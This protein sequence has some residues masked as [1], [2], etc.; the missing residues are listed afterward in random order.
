MVVV[1]VSVF[2]VAMVV[3]Q[4]EPAAPQEEEREYDAQRDTPVD[5]ELERLP[6]YCSIHPS[7]D[8][9]GQYASN[10]AG[11]PER[12]RW[13]EY[14]GDSFQ[15]MHHYC[16]ALNWLDRAYRSKVEQYRKNY[17]EFAAGEFAYVIRNAAPGLTLLPEVHVQKGLTLMLLGQTDEAVKDY[18]TAIQI[19]PDY[20]PAYSALCDYYLELGEVD[21][22][23]KIIE[24]GLVRVP[25]S[26]ILNRRLAEMES[27]P[28]S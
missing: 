9:T 4:E 27:E 23:R 16:W 21:E 26:K 1:L 12:T 7:L 17:F 14:F 11:T 3:A 8:G 6:A 15:H 28:T 20:V 25:H 13:E 2:G 19:R 24:A 18:L 10:M 5:D 22:A